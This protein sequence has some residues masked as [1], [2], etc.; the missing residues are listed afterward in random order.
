VNN[1]VRTHHTKRGDLHI[2][3]TRIS[4]SHISPELT[5]QRYEFIVFVATQLPVTC[6]HTF[7][8]FFGGPESIPKI[9][10]LIR[11]KNTYAALLGSQGRD[12]AT[13]QTLIDRHNRQATTAPSGDWPWFSLFFFSL[14]RGFEHRMQNF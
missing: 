9:N 12:G 3:I 7:C 1:R 5:V 4:L 14:V 2:Q 11:K 6:A 8:A 10:L 13:V